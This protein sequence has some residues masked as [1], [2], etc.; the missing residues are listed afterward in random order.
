MVTGNSL[1][2]ISYSNN[3]HVFGEPFIITQQDTTY[4]HIRRADLRK[5]ISKVESLPI[6]FHFIYEGE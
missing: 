2:E 6:E 5:W 3:T 1:W 4:M